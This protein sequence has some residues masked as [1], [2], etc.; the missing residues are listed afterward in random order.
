MTPSNKGTV[1]HEIT[2]LSEGDCIYVIERKKAEFNYPI[3]THK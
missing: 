2:P 1:L 3:H